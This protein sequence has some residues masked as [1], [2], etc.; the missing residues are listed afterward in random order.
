MKFLDLTGL[1]HF[2][3]KYLR[4][5]KD[6]AFKNVAN[7]LTTEGEGSVLDARQ[8]KAL[9]DLK[10]NIAK[11]INNLLTTE[12]GFAL[13][14]RQGKVLDDKI[15]ELNGNMAKKNNLSDHGYDLTYLSIYTSYNDRVEGLKNSLTSNP[16]IWKEGVTIC[17]VISSS[18]DDR[19][20]AIV[21]KKKNSDG[22][23]RLAFQ[24]WDY[25]GVNEFW[26]YANAGWES[27]N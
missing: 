21:M 22:A 15:T 20:M 16:T 19:G 18:S 17:Y 11:V 10:L 23:L 3:D 13:D 12:E 4:P 9:N 5:L 25:W 14:A 6:A 1:Q 7:D 27:S 24:Y 26:R 2:Y 8:G